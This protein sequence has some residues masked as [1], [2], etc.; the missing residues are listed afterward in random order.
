MAR[1]F[2]VATL[3]WA[4]AALPAARQQT[5][6]NTT[7]AQPP[8]GGILGRPSPPQPTQKQSLDYFVG[9]WQFKWTGRE[10][11]LTPGPRTGTVVF[12]RLGSTP[13]VEM[14]TQGQVDGGAAYE[15][16]GTLGWHAD[17]KIMAMHERLA[18]GIGVLSVG[19]WSSPIA[20]RF[21]SA[22]VRVAGQT[23]R[24]KRTFTILSATSFSVSEELAIDD[25]PFTRLG[26]G[27]FAR[28]TAR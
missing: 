26:S 7:P 15:E 13:F 28:Q 2:L 20:L 6:T 22:P 10:S 23:I 5:G 25:G 24:L 19:D 4:A 16:T 17:R 9:A 14:Q 8:A 11:P 18:G 27:V 1:I 12:Q 3:V 21:D